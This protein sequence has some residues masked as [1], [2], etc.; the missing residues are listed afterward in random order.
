[1]HIS[2]KIYKLLIVLKGKI[3]KNIWTI[4]YVSFKKKTKN[5]KYCGGVED[6][7][8]KKK[9]GLIGLYRRVYSTLE[10]T[11]FFP[12]PYE[13]FAKVIIC[14]EI[15]QNYPNVSEDIYDTAGKFIKIIQISRRYK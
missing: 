14:W 10:Y 13:T 5:K 1:M 4:W 6:L 7:K 8:K 9:L 12:N 11:F 3:Y 2:I 15:C